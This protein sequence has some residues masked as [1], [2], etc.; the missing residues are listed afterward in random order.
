MPR[1]VHAFEDCELDL[2][3]YQLRR[4]GRAVKLEPKVFDVLVH[5]L[6]H[7]D[8]VVTKL[9]LLDALW[10]GE[11]VSDSVLPRAIAAARRAV[12]DDRGSARVLATVHGR[13]YRFVAALRDRAS[14]PET[15][16]LAEEAPAF[17]SPFVGREALLAKLEAALASASAGRARIALLA[18]EPGI[19]K[20]RTTEELAAR[21]RASGALSAT[22]RCHEGEGAP[23]FWP[24]RGLLRALAARSER[25]ALTDAMGADASELALL[26]PELG[27]ASGV[28]VEGEPARFRLF[29][30][31][32]AF[33]RRLAQKRPLLLVLD[34]LHWADEASLRAFAFLAGELGEARVLLL[35]TYRD[36]EVHR[37]HPLRELLGKLARMPSCERLALRGLEPGALGALVS[38]VTGRAAS[39]EIASAVHEMTEGNPF[40]AVELARLLRDSPAADLSTLALPQSVR[41]AIGRRFD[42]L[43]P[44]AVRALRAAAV[45]GRSFDAMLLS[46][47]T[48]TAPDALLD[49]IGEAQSAGVLSEGAERAGSFSF[50]HALVR[51]TLLEE[52]RAPERVRLH[53]RAAEV[54][55]AALPGG[56]DG[57]LSEIAHHYFQALPGGCAEPAAAAAERAARNAHR[58]LA[59]EESARLYEQALEAL[60]GAPQPDPVRR[61]ELLAAAG[62]EHAAAGAREA[63]RSQ[64]RSA[65]NAARALGRADLLTRAAIGFRGLGEMGVPP[66]RETLELLEEARAALGDGQPVQRSRLL[67]RLTGTPPYS[68]SMATRDALSREALALARESGDPVALLDALGARSWACYGPDH[69]AERV[70]LGHE[71]SALGRR[72]RDP[73]AEFSGHESRF[74]TSLLLGSAAEADRALEECVRI[75]HELRYA[76]VLFQARYFEAARI[77][78]AGRLAD[79]DRALEAALQVGRGRFPYAQLQCD[80]HR[81]WLAIQRGDRRSARALAATLLPDI[82]FSWRGGEVVARS[83][84]ALLAFGEGKPEAGRALLAELGKD[85]FTSLERN[86]H[87]LLICATL[88]DLIEHF[89]DAANAARLYAVLSPYAHL[90]AFHDLL[91]TSAGSVASLLGELSFTLGRHDEAIAHYEAGLAL[92]ERIGAQAARLSTLVQIARA[93]RKRRRAGDAS[94]ASALLREVAATAPALGM[95]WA[96][97]FHLDPQTLADRPRS[98]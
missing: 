94:R 42:A 43:S 40:F 83:A 50:T 81:L 21:A 4:R 60:A 3:L 56:D 20:T 16:P 62:S 96:E 95:D 8:R 84:S 19:G 74:A 58:L 22:G 39:A 52:L 31:L 67:S 26:A 70:E 78:C 54:L 64:F 75:A 1:V 18:G 46:R 48:E 5:L 98:R 53:R 13:G 30:A 97:R 6:A 38:A 76:F 65:A 73:L 9:E 88:C 59:Y 91:R 57:A 32:A 7:R 24:W 28:A 36:V 89:G 2:G 77:A 35:G 85:G 72:L 47:L 66:E 61:F 51:Q 86:E 14:E 41:D 29:D 68:L 79:A 87:F 82:A 11:T 93:L 25:T 44:A 90:L 49:A 55:E 69:V 33:V 45:L 80:A 71:L 27:V 15:V 63:A 37:E 17:A 12:G 34:D 92:E 23:A 10:P